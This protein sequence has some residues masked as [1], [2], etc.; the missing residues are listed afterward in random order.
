ML[1]SVEISTYNGK[2]LL[3]R[4][5]EELALQTY[6]P[7]EFEVVVSDDGSSDGLPEA[8]E[9][10]RGSLPYALRVLRNEH[11][12]PANA[13]NLG[14]RA[15]RGEIVVMLA[16]DVLAAPELLEGHVQAHR[17]HPDER[18]VVAGR[19]V[20]SPELPA[21]AFQEGWNVLLNRLFSREKEDLRHGGF[22][23]SNLSFKK[24]FMTRHGMFRDMPPASQEDLELAHRLRQQGMKLV[25][26]PRALGFHHHPVTLA[27]V[28]R[29]AYTQGYHW[30]FFA[31]SVPDPWVRG[32][33]GRLTPR[34]GWALYLRSRLKDALR[35]CLVNEVTVPAV[36][37]PL[38]R[39]AERWRI[40]GRLVPF[41][42]GKVSSHYFHRGL[43]DYENAIP[44]RSAR[45]SI[46]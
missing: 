23:V 30:H 45:I 3:Q 11:R 22:F 2:E 25:P 9:S 41:L 34:D 36:A 13:H 38:I 15:C 10:M 42:A 14:I 37:I 8:V 26:S 44:E 7:S 29:R 39:A 16:S 27:D 21:T 40:L 31:E 18:V 12:G 35:R 43:T 32:R 19:L 24:R 28:A 1:T 46:G 17:E 33:A 4:V 20:Q 6:P 5:L